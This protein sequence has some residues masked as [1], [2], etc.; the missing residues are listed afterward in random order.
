MQ[1]IQRISSLTFIKE[2]TEQEYNLFHDN[3]HRKKLPAF[4]AL[5][6]AFLPNILTGL[7]NSNDR[8]RLKQQYI[9]V[10]ERTRFDLLAIMTAAASLIKE[11]HRDQLN[12]FLIETWKQQHS[13]TSDQQMTLT[14]LKIIESKQKNIQQCLRYIYKN[15]IDF[16]IHIPIV[17]FR[18]FPRTILN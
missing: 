14:M 2:K 17:I 16:F 7:R 15:K 6:G 18:H 11:H 13:S 5:F 10:I 4:C 1:L 9:Q 3:V 8:V 12:L